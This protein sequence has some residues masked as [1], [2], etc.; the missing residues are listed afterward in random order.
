MSN[1]LLMV[2]A[3]SARRMAAVSA[4]RAPL[5]K[6]VDAGGTWAACERGELIGVSV[7]SQLSI[8][9]GEQRNR[10]NL[11]GRL[12]AAVVG[13]HTRATSNTPR[14]VVHWGGVTTLPRHR[15]GF[16]P[17]ACSYYVRRQRLRPSPRTAP[18]DTHGAASAPGTVHVVLCFAGHLLRSTLRDSTPQSCLRKSR[19]PCLWPPVALSA[20]RLHRVV[21]V[22]SIVQNATRGVTI[23]LAPVKNRLALAAYPAISPLWAA[24]RPLRVVL[25]VNSGDVTRCS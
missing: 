25:S 1:T 2:H 20:T 7:M 16:L 18:G 12:C 22:F 11:I 14:G 8:G 23:A 15:G 5:L 6:R 10:I 3:A 19:T 24:T 4:R 21:L 9:E 13:G 17:H